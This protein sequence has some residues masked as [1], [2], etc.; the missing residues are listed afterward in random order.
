MAMLYQHAAGSQLRGML[1]GYFLVGSTMSLVGLAFVGR[2]GGEELL[3]MAVLLPG[4]GAGFVLSALTAPVLDR[5]YVRLAV[6][7]LS[8]ASAGVI[9]LT[10]LLG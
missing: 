7:V 8:A 3:A 2:F 6:L 4:M 1:A 10:Q 5:G 9:V